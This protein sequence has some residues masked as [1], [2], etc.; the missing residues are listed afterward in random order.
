M[1]CVVS[2]EVIR[3]KLEITKEKKKKNGNKQKAD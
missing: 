1:D 2:E 3:D